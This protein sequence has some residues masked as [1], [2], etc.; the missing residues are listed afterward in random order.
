MLKIKN[1]VLGSEKFAIACLLL[2][3]L[4]T[5]AT[6]LAFPQDRSKPETIEATARGTETQTGKEFPVTLTIYE[7]SGQADKQILTEAFQNGREAI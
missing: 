4:L 5:V 2:L 6:A 1:S 3:G 7:Y